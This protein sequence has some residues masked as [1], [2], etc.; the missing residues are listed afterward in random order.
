MTPNDKIQRLEA[1]ISFFDYAIS[2]ETES[3]ITSNVERY[4]G[5]RNSFQ[6][7]VDAILLGGDSS[8]QILAALD[9]DPK[10]ISLESVYDQIE[11][12]KGFSQ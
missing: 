7:K 11:R 3:G 6:K 9:F 10:T 12:E 8:I 4:T 1:A 5:L 2:R